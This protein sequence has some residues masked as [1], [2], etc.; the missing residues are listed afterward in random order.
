MH[1]ARV[2]NSVSQ[3]TIF[4]AIWFDRPRG[5]QMIFFS[6]RERSSYETFHITQKLKNLNVFHRM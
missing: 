4:W 6:S 2:E 1:P 5:W 3:N